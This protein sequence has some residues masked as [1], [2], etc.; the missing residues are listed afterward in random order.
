MQCRDIASGMIKQAYDLYKNGWV[1]D[2]ATYNLSE[3]LNRYDIPVW[4]DMSDNTKR[5]AIE[6]VYKNV[7]TIELHSD[8]VESWVQATAYFMLMVFA[9]FISPQASQYDIELE[10]FFDDLDFMMEYDTLTDRDVQK[11][12]GISKDFTNNF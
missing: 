2:V 4:N 9:N 6:Y 3:E 10:M 1:E 5:A 7:D 12:L 11:Q 8:C